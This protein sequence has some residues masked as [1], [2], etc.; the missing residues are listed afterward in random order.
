MFFTFLSVGKEIRIFIDIWKLYKIHI[1]VS[2]TKLLLEHKHNHSFMSI[3]TLGNLK[4]HFKLT[5]RSKK[6]IMELE[7]ICN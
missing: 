5:H 3:C 1:S 2:I 4:A 7:N 6:N